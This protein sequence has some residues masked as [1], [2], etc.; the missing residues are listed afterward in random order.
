MF[1]LISN[2][3]KHIL[4]PGTLSLEI[5]LIFTSTLFI[6]VVII[7]MELSIRILAVDWIQTPISLVLFFQWHL[8]NQVVVV[9]VVP[10][11]QILFH[12]HFLHFFN[13][14]SLIPRL[15]EMLT[16]RHIADHQFHSLCTYSWIFQLT[17][18]AIA[19]HVW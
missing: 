6:R 12:S 3:V 14:P 16:Y 4:D 13:L 1:E 11:I 19:L 10:E 18:S 9:I 17:S 7:G 2:S 15:N 5:I 8:I